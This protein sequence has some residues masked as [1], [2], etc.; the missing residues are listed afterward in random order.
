MGIAGGGIGRCWNT[1][2]GAAA[3]GATTTQSGSV[4][5][6]FT[7]KADG[8]VTNIRKVSGATAL[9][10]KAQSLLSRARACR[11]EPGTPDV[12]AQITY[13]FTLN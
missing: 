12:Q 6:A 13:N 5:L 8:Q 2:P 7:V 4:T 10:S 9:F 3:R 11:A 1:S